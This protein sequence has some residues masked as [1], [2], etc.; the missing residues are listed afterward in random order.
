[1]T[2]GV[3]AIGEGMTI[4]E[5]DASNVQPDELSAF[6]K[7][8]EGMPAS[9][10]RD[11]V[12]FLTQSVENGADVAVVEAATDLTPTQVAKLLK[13]S[14]THLYKLLD[15][16]ALPWHPV[17]RDRR[18]RLADFVAFERRRDSDRREL[19]ERFAH[20]SRTAEGALDELMSEL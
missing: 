20:T 17:G 8:A 15:T 7:F 4:T 18:I 14:R 9:A 1:M 5:V 3:V 16:G 11:A 13:M 12:L 10:L 2:S 6:T 19:A